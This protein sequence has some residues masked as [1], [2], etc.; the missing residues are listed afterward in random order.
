MRSVLVA[1]VLTV[2]A[3]ATTQA[4]QAKTPSNTQSTCPTNAI[5][6]WTGVNYTGVQHN[7]TSGYENV[8]PAWRDHTYSFIANRAGCFIDWSGGQKTSRTVSKGDY[9]T[10]YDQGFGKRIDGIDE[11]C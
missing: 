3:L 5:C 2:A 10:R 11:H 9:A 8:P 7:W 1:G 4:A 6:I